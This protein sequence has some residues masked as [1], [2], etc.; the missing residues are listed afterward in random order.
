MFKK[1]QP[2][3]LTHNAID[4]SPP[5]MPIIFLRKLT[6]IYRYLKK[7]HALSNVEQRGKA[8]TNNLFYTCNFPEIKTVTSWMARQ[9]PKALVHTVT[10][11]QNASPLPLRA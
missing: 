11:K 2:K 3:V 4:M 9:F 1:V 10:H 6:S 5:A 7:K 8:N